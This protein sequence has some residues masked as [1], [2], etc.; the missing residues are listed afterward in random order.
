MEQEVVIIG[1]DLARNVFL[2]QAIVADGE[3]L[4]RRKLS[5][6]EVIRFFGELSPCL[7]AIEACASAHYWARELIAFGHKVHLM[8]QAYVRPYVKR[9][10]TDAADA[11]AVTRPTCALW[12]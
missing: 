3:V 7:V 8:P 11:E 10:K 4:I 2:V 1:L 5:F 12:L 6:S 9:G